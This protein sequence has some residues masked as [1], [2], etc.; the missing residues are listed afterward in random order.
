[1]L[2]LPPAV[3]R[4]PEPPRKVLGS[5]TSSFNSSSPVLSSSRPIRAK[6]SAQAV[7]SPTTPSWQPGQPVRARVAVG[8]TA[9]AGGGYSSAPTTPLGSSTLFARGGGAPVSAVQGGVRATLSPKL[10]S[11]PTTRAPSPARARSPDAP[12]G[13]PV[14]KVGP[15]VV[16]GVAKLS[17]PE[18]SLL[19]GQSDPFPATLSSAESAPPIS[20]LPSSVSVRR[21]HSP[22]LRSS[23]SYGGNSSAAS[24]LDTSAS[25]ASLPT[26]ST[27]PSSAAS[28]PLTSPNLRSTFTDYASSSLSA[29]SPSVSRDGSS[30]GKRAGAG[31]RRTSGVS[32]VSSVSSCEVSTTN[33]GLLPPISIS[34]EIHH[35]VRSHSPTSYPL[36]SPPLQPLP[37]H[38][39]PSLGT[40]RSPTLS[41]FPSSRS[42][43]ASVTS[44]PLSSSVST[45]STSRP[46]LTSQNPSQH[47]R[48][49]RSNS[50]VS[51]SSRSS[52]L[53]AQDDPLH[54]ASFSPSSESVSFGRARAPPLAGGASR[55]RPASPSQPYGT[56]PAAA[57][58]T[59]RPP[60]SQV[61][62][63]SFSAIEDADGGGKEARIG[64][65]GSGGGRVSSGSEVSGLS[66]ERDRLVA[67]SSPRKEIGDEERE[68]RVQRKILDLEIT[69]SS[70]LS[71]NASLERLKLKHTSEIRELRR[72]M[73]ESV[74]GAGLAAL[75]A[76][77][78]SL[79]EGA[80]SS[81]PED[82][83]QDAEEGGGGGEE[84][85][86]TWQEILDG[87]A[88]FSAVAATL[89][90]LVRR[91]K[92]ALEYVPAANEGGRVLST[93]EM[94]DRL[95]VEMVEEGV[96]TDSPPPA[97]AGMG[98]GGTG[99]AGR[100][101]RGLGIVGWQ[102]GRGR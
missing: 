22:T 60:L 59:T 24:S 2:T 55:S 51:T 41:S 20:H 9:R 10:A 88:H 98:T 92:T 93:V 68:A 56:A 35:T 53:S 18:Q 97:P 66:I 78:A 44:P 101:G 42:I 1:M 100:N 36:Q 85:E 21:L 8:G 91:A 50:G 49:A 19:R 76:Q 94:E 33:G 80:E 25:T 90:T 39:T 62:W 40:V 38:A 75:R 26:L 67:P 12:R 16:G 54:S 79:D 72:R 15:R 32:S 34:G 61:D 3:S 73:R 7:H 86:Q 84:K 47:R 23:P 64:M 4:P 57:Q 77:A 87:D 46:P 99:S 27:S 5:S 96:Q 70:L 11:S 95:E 82:E 17:T 6:V 81:D 69:N 43:K 58:G 52:A 48:H 13:T 74:G 28:S 89:E 37:I 102:G 14:A 31:I 83:F 63:T 45:S 65:I 30:V 29:G 71:I